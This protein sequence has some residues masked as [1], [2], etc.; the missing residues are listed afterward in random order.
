MGGSIYSV[1]MVRFGEIALKSR[2]IRLRMEGRLARNIETQ[3]RLKGLRGFRVRVRWSRLY[4]EL[5]GREDLSKYL[6]VLSKVFGVVSFSP[7][8]KTEL[9]LRSIREV[10]TELALKTLRPGDTFEVRVNRGNKKF[11]ITSKELEKILGADVLATVSGVKVDLTKPMK[12]IYVDIREDA[13][14]VF[15]EEFRGPGGLPYGV[16]GRVASLVSG[17]VDSA[18]ATWL[19]MKRG[20]DVVPIHFN[21]KPYYGDDARVR[22][23]DV[24]KWL[25]EWVPKESWVAYEVPLGEVHGRVSISPRYRC[26]LCKLL[27]YRVAEEIARSEGCKA[28]VTGEALGQVATQTL[29][30]LYFL[31]TKVSI[32]ILRPLVGMD[33]EEIIRLAEGLGIKELTTKKVLTCTLAPSAQGRKAETHASDYVYGVIEDSVRSAGFSD[34]SD[35]VNYLVIK[36]IRFEVA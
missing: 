14:Y 2:K 11:P 21:L 20:C 3:L 24:L 9:N 32:P 23:L 27:M 35:V 16:E 34:L 33:K 13:A 17:G 18:V 7:C 8:V 19:I 12:G 10:V 6:G 5:L 28:L 36:S 29:D 31:T 4:I 30:N 15:T 22:A 26:L 1:I 25:R